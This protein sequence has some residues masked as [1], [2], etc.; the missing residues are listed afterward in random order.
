MID[1]LNNLS[2]KYPAI[3]FEE[4]FSVMDIPEEEKEKRIEIAEKV[5][6]TYLWLFN[7]IVLMVA[8]GETIDTES[9]TLSVEYRLSEIANV[10]ISYV[11]EHIT[12]LAAETVGT[13]VRNAEVDYY[14]S[15]QRASEIAADEAHTLCE[16]TELQEAY[17]NGKTRKTWHTRHDRRV[18]ESHVNLDSKTIPITELFETDGSYLMCP[19]DTENGADLKEISGCRCWLTF[20]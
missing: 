19:H 8:T 5:N 14:V 9:L 6:D 18:R 2:R 12:R 4:W 11:S 7:L 20:S 16:Y 17:E 15:P 13:T 1:R 3:D 10:N